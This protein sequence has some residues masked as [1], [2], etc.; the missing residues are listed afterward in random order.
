MGSQKTKNWWALLAHVGSYHLFTLAALLFAGV[1][2][3]S[4]LWATLFLAATHAFLDRRTPEIWWIKKIKKMPEVP[5][6]ILV[7]VDQ[8]FHLLLLVL[9]SFLLG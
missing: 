1:N 3:I 7:C 9:V 2:L 4:A 6:W 8:S 5:F